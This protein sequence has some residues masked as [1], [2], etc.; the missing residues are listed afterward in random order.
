MQRT[1]T[2]NGLVLAI[3]TLV[4]GVFAG[5]PL[6]QSQQT[7]NSFELAPGVV[8]DLNTNRAYVMQPGGGIA[9][10]SLD[11]GDKL[12]NS[13]DAAKPLTVSGNLLVSQAEPEEEANELEIVTLNA[14]DQGRRVFA[15]TI[16]LPA[17]VRPSITRS[18]ARSFTATADVVTG[19]AAVTWEYQERFVQGK[20]PER[21]LLP[22]ETESPGALPPGALRTAQG[23]VVE[24]GPKTETANGA[25]RL[26]LKSGA[27]TPQKP[28]RRSA[29]IAEAG[30]AVELSPSQQLS[31]VPQPQFLSADG[32]YVLSPK[33]ATDGAPWDKYVW[34]IYDRNTGEPR[35]EFRTHVRYAP[36]FVAGSLVVY[37][38]GPYER[39]TANGMVEEPLQLRAVNLKNGEIVWS[40]PIR[41][42]VE[43]AAP[44]P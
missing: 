21:E 30:L 40:Q 31:G 16:P 39:K 28:E 35:G 1:I 42:T 15:Q 19:D 5:L 17:R 6:G 32:K 22:G 27:V 29:P 2:F 3:A 23:E 34:T 41:D 38:I 9:A 36:F 20:R 11:R 4:S 44:P 14:E 18:A 25:F 10:L 26:N 43:R 7:A 12:W 24:G 37:Q 8:V 33:L 13:T